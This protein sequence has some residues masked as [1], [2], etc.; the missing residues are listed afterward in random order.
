MTAHH[1][2]PAAMRRLSPPW[3]DLTWERKRKL[4]ELPHT[5]ANEQAALDALTAALS[6]MPP[7]SPGAWSDESWEFFYRFRDEASH[8]LS[9][10]MPTAD[11]LTREGVTDILR[12]WVATAVPPVPGRWFEEQSEQIAGTWA[13]VV[14]SGWAH[15]VLWWLRQEPQ[16]KERIAAVAEHCIRNDLSAQNAVNLLKALGVPHGEKALLRVV[17]DG[18]VHEPTRAWA[19][20]QLIDL[21]LPGYDARGQEP[22]Q[23]EEALLPRAV[24]EL[25]YRWGSGFKW[26]SDLPE[27]GENLGRA[28]SILEARVPVGPVPEPIP[29][30]AWD[31]DDAERPVWLEVHSVM[32]RLMPYTRQVTRERMTEAMRECALLGIPGIPQDPEGEEAEQFVRQWVTWISSQITGEVFV[33]LGM[34]VDDEARVTPWAMELAEQYARNGV[35]AEQAVDML[36]W[37]RTVPCSREALTRIAA[38]D[39]LPPQVREAAQDGLGRE[40]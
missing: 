17:R 11:L 29:T 10:V 39:S 38:D 22:A 27:S 9:H 13:A 6:D 1:L 36:R 35:A 21:R 25:P 32:S 37:H 16:D 2:L 18:R 15:D 33:W 34:Y 8:R 28:R 7:A 3:N 24:R 19:R 30:Q 26:P 12:G 23:G 5:E 20:D 31:K 4:E 40:P 14:L